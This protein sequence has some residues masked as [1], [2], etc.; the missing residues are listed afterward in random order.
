[1][2]LAFDAFPVRPGA[3]TLRMHPLLDNA[4]ALD[5]KTATRDVIAAATPPRERFNPLHSSDHAT[6][7]WRIAE[8]L[9]PGPAFAAMRAG[10]AARRVS[11][12]AATGGAVPEAG[13]NLPAVCLRR[14]GAVRRVFRPHLAG[15]GPSVVQA[16]ELLRS[17]GPEIC[18]LLG[19]GEGLVDVADPGEAFAPAATL[20]GPLPF[21]LALRL[22]ALL[23][24]AAKAGIV[25]DRWDPAQTVF[26]NRARTELRLLGF[27]R[28]RCLG[29]PQPLSATLAD[30]ATRA[31]LARLTGIPAAVFFGGSAVRMRLC[32]DVLRPTT[33]LVRRLEAVVSRRAFA[34]RARLSRR[35]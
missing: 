8:K 5:A 10:V 27:D 15:H 28:P 30:P 22:R 33:G 24:E 21:A 25:L 11:L 32:R 6:E 18:G 4:R 7:A 9:L 23:E 13:R 14:E 20:G 31:D 17:A 16:Q 1:M 26:V 29:G 2:I 19:T 35:G 3:D 34:L 12:C